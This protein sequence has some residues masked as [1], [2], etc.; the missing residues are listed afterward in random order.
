MDLLGPSPPSTSGNRW[1]IVAKKYLTRYE[2][3]KALPSETAVE[4]AKFSV[5]AI[6]LRRDAPEVLITYR[7]SS[8]MAQLPQEILCLSDTSHRRT[9]FY[10]RQISGLIERLDNAIANMNS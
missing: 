2:E 1:V 4:V 10:H 6:L 8:F 5:E 7:G 3:T 9:T